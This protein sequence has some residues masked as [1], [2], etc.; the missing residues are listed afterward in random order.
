MHCHVCG[1]TFR[2]MNAEAKH[3][4]NFPALCN[5]KSR[6]WKEFHEELENETNGEDH[7]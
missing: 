2:T 5:T 1:K 3:R 4:H 7:D 6:R